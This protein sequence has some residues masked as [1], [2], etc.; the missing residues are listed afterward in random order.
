MNDGDASPPP[1][2]RKPTVF[3]VQHHSDDE[4]SEQESDRLAKPPKP[5]ELQGKDHLPAN[6][7]NLWWWSSSGRRTDRR[8]IPAMVGPSSGEPFLTIPFA[9]EEETLEAFPEKYIAY[10]IE[11]KLASGKT[12]QRSHRFSEFVAFH[13]EWKHDY[14]GVAVDLPKKLMSPS[15]EDIA[16]R[17]NEL[18]VYLRQML[19]I[20][21]LLYYVASL[22]GCTETELRDALQLKRGASKDISST[23]IVPA[24]LHPTHRHNLPKI[25]LGEQADVVSVCKPL[26]SIPAA[27]P[28]VTVVSVTNTDFAV[29]NPAVGV[30]AVDAQTKSS[31]L[32]LDASAPNYGMSSAVASRISERPTNVTKHLPA[33]STKSF[34]PITSQKKAS[35][36]HTSKKQVGSPSRSPSRNE[37]KSATTDF[38]SKGTREQVGLS[39]KERMAMFEKKL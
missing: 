11:L 26:P 39:V 37:K 21:A 36:R 25:K 10:V 27:V 31:F 8:E 19:D 4:M 3:R 22:I 13:K 7:F 6:K 23:Y 17:C 32:T 34:V 15:D 38:Q 24:S 5:K 29:T 33:A 14:P 2:P 16:R 9:R 30:K 20:T 28:P 12:V 1:K 18:Q 35:P